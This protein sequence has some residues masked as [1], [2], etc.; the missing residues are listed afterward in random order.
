MSLKLDEGKKPLENPLFSLWEYFVKKTTREIDVTKVMIKAMVNALGGEKKLA[1]ILLQAKTSERKSI[2]DKARYLFSYQTH[3]WIRNSY[4]P[5]AVFELLGLNDKKNIKEV[6]PDDFYALKHSLIFIKEP[7]IENLLKASDSKEPLKPSDSKE[8]LKPSDSK[9]PL[10]PSDSKEPL[11]PSDS[12]EPS[13]PSDSKEPSEPSDSKE[14]SEP[15][16]LKEPSEPSET[17]DLTQSSLGKLWIEHVLT[18]AKSGPSF[19]LNERDKGYVVDVISKLK[20]SVSPSA[21]VYVML[22]VLE[23]GAVSLK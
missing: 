6:G 18:V 19:K 9:E 14:P 12:K 8:P 21:A 1:E 2:C 3:Y 7:T 20:R 10:K 17:T 13:K 16:D 5:E 22:R 15:S 4:T 23:G 11:K